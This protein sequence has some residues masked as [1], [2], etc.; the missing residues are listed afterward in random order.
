[1]EVDL[2]EFKPSLVYKESSRLA[3]GYI[4]RPRLKNKQTKN[5]ATTKTQIKIT[6]NHKNKKVAAF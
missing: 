4:V 1:M 5:K 6:K 2:Y 3:R